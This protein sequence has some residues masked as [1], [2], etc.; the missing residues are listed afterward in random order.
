MLYC[1]GTKIKNQNHEARELGYVVDGERVVR[2]LGIHRTADH[3]AWTQ[4]SGFRDQ[5]VEYANLLNESPV[6]S[7][8]SLIEVDISR[9]WGGAVTDHA[10]DQMKLV[11]VGKDWKWRN[12]RYTRGE[13]M[14]RRLPVEDRTKLTTDAFAQAAKTRGW[15]K[16]T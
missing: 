13:E 15:R 7:K 1:H 6:S 11:K 5:M 3:K 16:L 8:F 2:S 9:R 4:F 12:D 10:A 14:L